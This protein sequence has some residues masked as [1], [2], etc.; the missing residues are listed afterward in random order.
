MSHDL[1][2]RYRLRTLLILM[3]LGPPVL[4]GVWTG[5][6]P[7]LVVL[8]GGLIACLGVL[9]VAMVLASI[10]TADVEHRR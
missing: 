4:A 7:L 2:M 6:L 8:W 9:F 10:G 3:A 5:G 1:S